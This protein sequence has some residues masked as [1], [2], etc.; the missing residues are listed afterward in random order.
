MLFKCRVANAHDQC[1]AIA[2]WQ[3]TSV[4]KNKNKNKKTRESQLPIGKISYSLTFQHIPVVPKLTVSFMK[5][6]ENNFFFLIWR[7]GLNEA[8]ELLQPLKAVYCMPCEEGEVLYAL[9]PYTTEHDTAI[10]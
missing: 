5:T 6:T 9:T 10:K 2:V 1:Y 4:Q 8:N 7:E 3:K